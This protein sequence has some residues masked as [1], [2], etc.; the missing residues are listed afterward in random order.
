MSLVACFQREGFC[1]TGVSKLG[2]VDLE[3]IVCNA[4][5][6]FQASRAFANLQV[7]P[8]VR[9]ELEEVVLGDDLFRKYVQA[10]L[11][12]L[13]ARHRSIVIIIIKYPEC[14]NGHRRWRSCYSKGT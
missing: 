14:R 3:P 9:C 7:H 4:A 12:I 5:G 10:D 13:I 2:E 11:C 1:A 8:S 6:P